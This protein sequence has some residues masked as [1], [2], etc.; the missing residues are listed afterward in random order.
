MSDSDLIKEEEVSIWP[1]E[2]EGNCT[3]GV[4]L[5]DERN[6]QEFLLHCFVDHRQTDHVHE[7]L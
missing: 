6:L 5:K 7:S 4:K 2:R 1:K 3:A